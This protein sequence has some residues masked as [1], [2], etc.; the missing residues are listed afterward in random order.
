MPRKIV[1][2]RK[3]SHIRNLLH[4]QVQTLQNCNSKNNVSF[5]YPLKRFS[6]VFRGYRNGILAGKG[7]IHFWSGQRFSGIFREYKMGKL[8]R[9][10]LL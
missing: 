8:A 2:F 4:V 10:E 3:F 6:D 9:N 1:S 7:L 5:P